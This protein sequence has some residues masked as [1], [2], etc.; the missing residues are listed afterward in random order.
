MRLRC[1]GELLINGM[2]IGGTFLL[3]QQLLGC[4]QISSFTRFD[5]Y[6][7]QRREQASKSLL[8][9][10]PSADGAAE[11]KDYLQSRY[12]KLESL[13]YY[14]LPKKA[15]GN[16]G[17]GGGGVGGT[18][19]SYLANHAS[20]RDHHWLLAEFSS[21]QSALEC[22]SSCQHGEGTLPFQSSMLFY[23]GLLSNGNGASGSKS[24]R[25]NA[26]GGATKRKENS[27][28][29]EEEGPE[30]Q[31]ERLTNEVPTPNFKK[32]KTLSDQLKI[33]EEST[34]LSELGIRVRFF[35]AS[36]LE[37]VLSNLFPNGCILPFGST[38]SGIGRQSGDLDLVMVPDTREIFPDQ[39]QN[40]KASSSSNGKLLFHSK[41]LSFQNTANARYQTQKV[42]EIMGD[43]IQLFIPGC[44]H[45]QR[46]LQARVPI[47]RFGSDFT[48]LQCDLSMTNS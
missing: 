41:I 16:M 14:T 29:E 5:E 37:Q 18:A 45:L 6:L 4:R 23:Q 28:A 20:Q 17:G 32:G 43:V 1:T 42:M 47:L 39:Q 22:I 36:Q 19:L 10:V 30:M 38:V 27:S 34:K 7:T 15:K 40:L 12:G 46:I 8:I 48:D 26:S 3:R 33:L 25:N 44:V 11:V 35:V 13:Y 21:K 2:R 24:R 9:Q 31:T